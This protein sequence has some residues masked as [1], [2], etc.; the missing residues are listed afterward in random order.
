MKIDSDICSKLACPFSEVLPG[1]VFL[2]DGEVFIRATDAPYVG[3]L[4][5]KLSNGDSVQFED[6]PLVKR[7]DAV[8]R[9]LG[10]I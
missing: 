7:L 3:M 10:E 2:H 4:A 6:N 1:N 9:I 5:V 8:C